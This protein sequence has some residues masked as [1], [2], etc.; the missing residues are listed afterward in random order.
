MHPAAGGGDLVVDPVV[1][2][3]LC[4][5]NGASTLGRQLGALARQDV[6]APWEVV[7]VDNGSTDGTRAVAASWTT[8]MPWLR[9][10]DEPVAG[11]NRA[12]NRAVAVARSDRVL[13]CDADDELDRA[14]VR[15]MLCG[16]EHDDVVGGALVPRPDRAARAR[17]LAVPQTDG[18]PSIL[19]HTFAVGAS[20]GFHRRVHD[21]VGGFDERFGTGADE[22]DF[23][24]RAAHAG[25]TIGFVPTAVAR[26][27]LQ[28]TPSTLMRQRFN[29]GRGFQRL[30]AKAAQR[31]WIRRTRD[32]RWNDLARAGAP[33]LW[34]WPDVLRHDERLPYL[35]RLAHVAGEATELLVEAG[36]GR[37]TP[38]DQTEAP[39]PTLTPCAVAVGSRWRSRSQ[40]SRWSRGSRSSGSS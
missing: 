17:L 35:A 2:V 11:L 20:L 9:V 18:L 36:R 10:V 15:E 26:Y 14:W 12:R 29:Y 30:I 40:R 33:L 28:D 23:C 5:R 22:V 16:L 3:V 27:T 4:V 13:C 6:E 1:S 37:G 25:F 34:T 31:G 19:D 24:M 21:A 8:R 39:R 32:E 7:V 38:A